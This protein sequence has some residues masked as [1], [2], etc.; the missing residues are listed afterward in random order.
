MNEIRHHQQK[1]LYS[2]C[3][4]FKRYFNC[5]IENLLWFEKDPLSF[6]PP[7]KIWIV[8]LS[9]NSNDENSYFIDDW[10][11]IISNHRGYFCVAQSI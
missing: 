8:I 9:T 6:S 5:T 4:I 3:I 10:R 11:P 2:F 1:N 7:V